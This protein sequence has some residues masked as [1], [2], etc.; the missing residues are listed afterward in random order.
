MVAALPL[1]LVFGIVSIGRAEQVERVAGHSA[2]CPKAGPL[3]LL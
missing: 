3:P 1:T 2:A